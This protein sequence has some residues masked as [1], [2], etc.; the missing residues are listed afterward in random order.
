MTPEALRALPPTLTIPQAAEILGVSREVGYRA[1]AE[2]ELPG[3]LRL[4][5]RWIVGTA[6][7]LRAIGLEET[8]AAT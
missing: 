8:G 4:G 2:G 5:K 1:A 7:L 6:V 3:A